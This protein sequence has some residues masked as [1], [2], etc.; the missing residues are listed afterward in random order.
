MSADPKETFNLAW[1]SSRLGARVNSVEWGDHNVEGAVSNILKVRVT[2]TTDDGAEA[3]VRLILKRYMQD[4][5]C[6]LELYND[7]GL[8]READFYNSLE[9]S[10]GTTWSQIVC[11]SIL[12]R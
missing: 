2:K 8:G 4:S 3:D 6:D 11:H 9:V 1:F 7:F 5:L 10:P 12:L